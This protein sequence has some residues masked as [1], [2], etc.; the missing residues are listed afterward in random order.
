MICYQGVNWGSY[1]Q[2]VQEV[3]IKMVS[4]TLIWR[5]ALASVFR[6]I[7]LTI[8]VISL[9]S[10]NSEAGSLDR[11]ERLIG[12]GD[13]VL[14]TDSRG[15]VLFSKHSDKLLVPASVMKIL[16]C[17]TALH[18]L[19]HDYR[20]QTDF[21]LDKKSNLTIKGYGDPLLISET[22]PEIAGHLSQR[23]SRINDMVLDDTYFKAPVIIPGAAS[24]SV[25]PYDAPN[26]ALCVNFNTVVFKRTNNGSYVSAEP[27]TPLLPFVLERVTA[28]SVDE[29]RII[30]FQ[31]NNEFTMYAGHLFSY[32]F[33]QKEIRPEGRIRLGRVD[34]NKDQLV[35]RHISRFTME[36][37]VKGMLYYSNN[38][39]ANQLLI[40]AGA[41]E[42]GP[43]G[44]LE[45][46]VQA[47]LSYAESQLGIKGMLL[48]EGSGLSRKNRMSADIVAKTLAA[49]EP[50]HH[51]MRTNDRE[52]YKTGTLDGIHTR[53]GYIRTRTGGLIRFAVLVNTPGKTT[54]EIMKE[55][56]RR[57]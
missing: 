6:R 54:G 9:L 48:Y 29:G 57:F 14:V 49:F 55:I 42:F 20:F 3:N 10:L 38:F 2:W 26:G 31:E 50:Y 11:L 4:T 56:L 1:H 34:E 39:T 40:A 17:L 8:L 16:T 24:R 15:K 19:G 51:L 13:S 47:A 36:D 25:Q 22:L 21:F 46:G 52:F 43:P 30:L 27:Q 32:Y 33:Q 5:T 28:S 41:R 18:S 23:I 7:L 37:I 45:K 44:T 53:A 12:E 35:F